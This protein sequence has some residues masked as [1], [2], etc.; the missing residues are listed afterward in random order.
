[1]KPN[2]NVTSGKVE[3]LLNDNLKKNES[4]NKIKESEK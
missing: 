3:N 2:A 1:M 4:F